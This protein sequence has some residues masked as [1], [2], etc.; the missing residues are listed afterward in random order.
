VSPEQ[1]L[2]QQQAEHCESGAFGSLLLPPFMLALAQEALAAMSVHSSMACCRQQ[3]CLGAI[4]HVLCLA[5]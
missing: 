4:N 1:L 3:R 2:L 5:P